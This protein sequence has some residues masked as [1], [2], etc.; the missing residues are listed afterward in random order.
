MLFGILSLIYSVLLHIISIIENS[1]S[2]AIISASSS[3]FLEIRLYIIRG[4]P[5][6]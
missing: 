2:F 5:H 6:S 4:S 1:R 3:S